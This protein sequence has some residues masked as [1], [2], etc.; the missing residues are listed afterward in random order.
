MQ[1]MGEQPQSDLAHTLRQWQE[2]GLELEVRRVDAPDIGMP[3]QVSKPSW[4]GWICHRVFLAMG[5]RRG[6]RGGFGAWVPEASSG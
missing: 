1:L 2:Q 3:L 5:L 6:W 4:F